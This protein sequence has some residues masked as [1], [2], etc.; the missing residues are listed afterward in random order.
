[1]RSAFVVSA[2]TI[3]KPAPFNKGAWKKRPA[4]PYP[5]IPTRGAFDKSELLTTDL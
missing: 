1:L 5:A 2:P 3:E 4:N